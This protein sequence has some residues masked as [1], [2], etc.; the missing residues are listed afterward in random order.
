MIVPKHVNT[1]IIFSNF[2]CYQNIIS[3]FYIIISMCSK[4]NE[5]QESKLSGEKKLLSMQQNNF[6]YCNI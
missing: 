4:K 6:F 3:I 1:Y 5:I 2:Y